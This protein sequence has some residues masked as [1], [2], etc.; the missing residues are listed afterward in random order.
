MLLKPVDPK[1][2]FFNLAKLKLFL[3]LS[4]VLTN[5]HTLAQ[6]PVINLF[7][8]ISGSV[9]TVVTI[10]GSNFSVSAKENIVY[11]GG[12]RGTVSASTSTSLTV[13]VPK[14][15]GPNPLTVTNL[16]N[17]P[18]A[19]AAKPFIL[20]FSGGGN[21]FDA[22]SFGNPKS[23]RTQQVGTTSVA[24]G[25]IDGDGKPDLVSVN[26]PGG[27]ASWLSILRNTSTYSNI[28][29]FDTATILPP[30]PPNQISS[31]GNCVRLADING[32]GRL[33]IAMLSY[34]Q[35]SVYRNISVPGNINFA[36]MVKF[37]AS[38]NKTSELE[39]DDFDKDGKPD[40]AL[41]NDQAVC[42]FKNLSTTTEILMDFPITYEITTSITTRG[43][44]IGDIDGDNRPDICVVNYSDSL[45]I[46]R[47]LSGGNTILFAPP[48]RFFTGKNSYPTGLSIADIDG[49]LVADII[50]ANAFA[51]Q[52]LFFK[53][54]SKP[55]VFSFEILQFYPNVNSAKIETVDLNGDGKND[56]IFSTSGFEETAILLNSSSPCKSN[57]GYKTAFDSDNNPE[58]C[59]YDLNGDGKPELILPNNVLSAIKV[60]ENK[61]KQTIAGC[62]AGT[63]VI[64]S[65]A[66]GSSYQWQQNAGGGFLNISNNGTLSGTNS[67]SL[68]ITNPSMSWNGLSY[69]CIVNE[70][71]S[72]VF[73]HSIT[74]DIVPSISITNCPTDFCSGDTTIF[75]ATTKN[76]GT[77]PLFQ[78]QDSNSV[79]GWRNI[80]GELSPLLKYAT[81][82]PGTKVR[83]NMTGGYACSLPAIVTSNTISRNFVCNT[84]V[85]LCPNGGTVL[86]SNITSS[87][88]YW[89][90]DTGAGF[91]GISNNSNYSGVNTANLQISNMPSTAY[92]YKYRCSVSGAMYSNIFT[93]QF[94]DTW[95]GAASSAWENPANWSC[96]VVPDT[97]TDVVIQS[98]TILLNSNTTIRSLDISQSAK[99]IVSSG[100]NLTIKH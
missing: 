97:N 44:K 65:N 39:I 13:T 32:D 35:L 99:L 50:I 18:T 54:K 24:V 5:L 36:P 78:W 79:A 7:S 9:G 27:S 82:I 46:L 1:K 42:I 92:G 48:L 95:T 55:G 89:A 68:Q 3:I 100:N 10:Y 37:T 8:P 2:M 51:D 20:K 11:F 58:I 87:F 41:I 15:A 62:A 72:N 77:N 56:L 14:G 69:R 16:N 63:S 4:L 17:G 6:A 52:L 61:I 22:N 34:G 33:D 53:N 26:F 67:A 45:V 38:L 74:T 76:E 43:L 66:T 94:S 40:L 31:D 59:V 19:Y 23:F 12:V 73:F 64:T 80:T 25:D 75:T 60:Y 86:T 81:N 98:G 47:N 49:D 83:C 30:T 70:D 29:F 84:N 85:K 71:T 90:L 28:S 91:N 57:F 88:Y 96:N 93:L 21:F